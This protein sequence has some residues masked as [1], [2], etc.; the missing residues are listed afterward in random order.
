[1][2][3]QKID[4]VKK[5][6]PFHRIKAVIH[7]MVVVY[8]SSP[9]APDSQMVAKCCA[10]ALRHMKEYDLTTG[11]WQLQPAWEAVS[12]QVWGAHSAQKQTSKRKHCEA[13]Q[14]WLVS[15]MTLAPFCHKIASRFLSHI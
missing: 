4:R 12:V 6:R 9:F 5:S 2:S 8:N 3:V 14:F 15:I 13:P 11:Y 7:H 10:A 1:M